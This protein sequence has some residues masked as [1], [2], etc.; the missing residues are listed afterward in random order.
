M[1]REPW[2]LCRGIVFE[3]YFVDAI[4]AALQL[5]RRSCGFALG[6]TGYSCFVFRHGGRDEIKRIVVGTR[7]TQP[8]TSLPL[9]LLYPEI[10]HWWAEPPLESP[11]RLKC[12]ANSG[13][14]EP[15]RGYSIEFVI[16]RSQPF[17]R[18]RM[19]VPGI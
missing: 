6:G 5:V 9:R 16:C 18:H 1:F 2:A 4:L 3:R 11:P 15:I 10:T 8:Y 19:A 17:A 12:L 13:S 14:T 7:G